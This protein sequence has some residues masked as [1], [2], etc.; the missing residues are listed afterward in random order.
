MKITYTFNE[1][2]FELIDTEDKAYYLGLMYADGQ[3]NNEGN[4]VRLSLGEEDKHILESFVKYLGGDNKLGFIELNNKNINWSN[5]YYLQLSRKKISDDLTNL[6]CIQNKTNSVIFPNERQ[7]NKNLIRHFIR[8]YFDGDGSVWCGKRKIMLVKDR[9]HS[10]GERNRII[11]NVKFTI[12]GTID[13]IDN[14]QNVLVSEL[15]FKKNKINVSKKIENCVT[16]EYS[17]RVQL[18]KFYEYIYNDSE[19]YLIR[20]KLK[21]EECFK[22]N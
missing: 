3:N 22:I 21:F 19:I 11:Q 12:T 17:G 15:N 6:G 14:I 16:L 2:Y 18:K 8:G 20:K 1:N 9:K 5:Q 10:K 13:M 4:Y 7:L